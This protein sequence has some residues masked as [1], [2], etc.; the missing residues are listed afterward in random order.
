[1]TTQDLLQR[2]QSSRLLSIAEKAYWSQNLEKMTPEQREKLETILTE[3]E[4]LIWTPAVQSYV[5]MA[6]KTPQPT[7]A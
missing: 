7:L 5:D 3:A 4:A 1:M 6:T 2:I